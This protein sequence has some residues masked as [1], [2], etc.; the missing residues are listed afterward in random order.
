MKALKIAVWVVLAVIASAIIFIGTLTVFEYRPAAL[1]PIEI[2]NKQEGRVR[3]GN[4]YTMMTFNIGYAGLGKDEDFVMDGGKKGRPDSKPVVEGYFSGIQAIL[5]DHPSDFYCLQEVDRVSRRSYRINQEQG[6]RSSLGNAYASQFAYN[7]KALFVPFPLSLSDYM[8]TVN[9]GILTLTNRQVLG[10]ERHQFPGAF[11]WPLRIANLKRAML[12]SYMDIEDSQK[13]LVIINLH[14]SAY[15]SDGSLRDQEMQYL[16][17]FLEAQR[18]LGN[19]VIVGG[20]FNQTF[21]EADGLFPVQSDLYEAY[22]IEKDFLPAGYRFE[23][24]LSHP[25]CRLLNQPYVENT[26]G[27][28]YYLIDG[29][30]VSDSVELLAMGAQTTEKPMTIDHGF[31]YSDHNPVVMRFRLRL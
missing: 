23:V 21:P 19:Y 18:A 13:K 5:H 31:L 22:T 12:V 1:E 10:S 27:T 11:S 9:S 25:T 15:D 7:F 28:Q 6:I 17:S 26:E 16:A 4:D 3:I 8:G 30:I 20:D 14:M 2:H 24:D 29:F